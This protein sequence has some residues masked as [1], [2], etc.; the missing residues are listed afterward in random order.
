MAAVYPGLKPR[1]VQILPLRGE[2][3]L[4][5]SA[6]IERRPGTVRILKLTN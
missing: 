1:A 2:A 5:G 6:N 4:F 3:I